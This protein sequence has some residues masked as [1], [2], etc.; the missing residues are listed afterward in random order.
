[1]LKTTLPLLLIT[2][3][4]LTGCARRTLLITSEPAGA[5]VHLNDQEIGRTPI[6]LPFTYYGVYDVRLE[7]ED[8]KPLWTTGK[9]DPPWWAYP[10]PDFFAEFIPGLHDRIEWHYTLDPAPNP[11]DENI[12]AVNDRARQMRANLDRPMP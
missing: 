6:Q 7:N 10:G 3:L 11:A 8:S 5:L 1:M 2:A 12:D 4:L 9:A